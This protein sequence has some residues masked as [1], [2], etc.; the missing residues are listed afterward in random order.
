MSLSLPKQVSPIDSYFVIT[1]KKGLND[2]IF[3]RILRRC[4][5]QM[6]LIEK[7]E[8]LEDF[9]R[10]IYRGL[11]NNSYFPNVHHMRSFSAISSQQSR[12]IGNNSSL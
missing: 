5:G 9:T 10:E 4:I 12:Q 11:W 6:S 2:E 8:K 3:L 7:K 1:R